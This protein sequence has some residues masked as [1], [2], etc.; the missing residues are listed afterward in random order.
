MENM[1]NFKNLKEMAE[2][3]AANKDYDKALELYDKAI[4][5]APDEESKEYIKAE[6]YRVQLASIKDYR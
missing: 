5:I 4:A 3:Y 1:E 2:S 6:R